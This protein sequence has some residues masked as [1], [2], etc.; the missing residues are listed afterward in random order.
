MRRNALSRPQNRLTVLAAALL[1]SPLLSG[2]ALA[3]AVS[4]AF[5]NGKTSL[6]LRVR[7]EQVDQA[8]ALDT[9]DAFTARL[10]AGYATGNWQ[11][12]S[13]SFDFEHVQALGGEDYNSSINGKTR[14]SVVAD[15]ES[16]EVNQ[17]FLQYKNEQGMTL[18]YGR[19][20]LAF[21]NHRFIGNV[22]WRQNEQ[23]FDALSMSWAVNADLAL[24]IA[25]ITNANRVFSDK[26]PQGDFDMRSPLLNM[27]YKVGKL[28]E[29]TG[30]GYW[31]DF[32]KFVANSSR[33]LGARWVGKYAVND[34]SSFAYTLEAARQSDYGDNP[35]SFSHDYRNLELGYNWNA[36]SLQLGQETLGSNG[37]HALQT[38]LATLHAF[39]GWA[40]QFL[41]TPVKGLVDTR[42]QFGWKY[43]N[44]ALTL[45]HNDFQ[46]D[47]GSVD[48]GRE[49]G[50]SATWN[51]GK[52]YTFGAK[53]ARY[54][55]DRFSV[56]TDKF[57]LWAEV[58]Y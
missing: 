54:E 41:T 16:T 40:D 44:G 5:A 28:G 34:S 4:D 50:A 33:T 51:I 47:A 48:Y 19:Q 46:S 42:L 35:Q 36:F 45:M 25:Q 24:N 52:Q 21:D 11:N 58:R 57:W 1:A 55:A 56:D 37:T 7:Y 23:T 49:L 38:P 2:A 12:F 9:A 30:Y 8:N 39:N 29:L 43:A 6:D 17:A 10:R 31:L 15:P 22:G 18:R 27:K 13:L 14:Y 20:R 3:D 32:E 26:H 53:L